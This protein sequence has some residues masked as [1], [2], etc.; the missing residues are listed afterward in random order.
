MEPIEVAAILTLGSSLLGNAVQAALP[1]I[2]AAANGHPRNGAITAAQ[3]DTAIRQHT[4]D[5]P[6]VAELR[7]VIEAEGRQT[8]AALETLT[9]RIDY[10]MQAGD[11]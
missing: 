6:H 4:L 10:L 9:R 7:R 11:R 3:L 5:C 8:R 1:R 2:R